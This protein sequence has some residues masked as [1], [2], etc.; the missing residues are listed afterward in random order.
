MIPPATD[1]TSHFSGL[2]WQ[3]LQTCC[4]LRNAL[5]TIMPLGIVLHASIFHPRPLQMK[6]IVNV[7]II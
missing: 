1:P 4:I 6:T 7:Y 2:I 3:V 5:F